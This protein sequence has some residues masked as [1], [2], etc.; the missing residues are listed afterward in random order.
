MHPVRCGVLG[1]TRGK[2][3]DSKRGATAWFTQTL[4]PETTLP[5]AC[6]ENWRKEAENMIPMIKK[7]SNLGFRTKGRNTEQRGKW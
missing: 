2:T 5:R 1:G 6:A 7:A 3:G 4:K